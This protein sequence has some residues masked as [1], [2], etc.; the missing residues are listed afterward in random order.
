YIA[1]APAA[2][3]PEV[4]ASQSLTEFKSAIEIRGQSLADQG[5]LIETLD[6]PRSVAEHNAD[7]TFNPASVMKLA[8]S[9][10]ALAKLGP[11][12]RYRTNFRAGGTIDW[13]THTLVGDLIV[14]G[15]SNPAFSSLDADE[16]ALQLSRL[17]IAH[18]AGGLRIAGPFYYFARGY[19]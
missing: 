7:V 17:G 10:V 2:S 13:N 12:Y 14:Q 19:H 1:I 5:V 3:E 9:F 8:T 11:D 18:I 6:Q 16:V 15:G 4:A